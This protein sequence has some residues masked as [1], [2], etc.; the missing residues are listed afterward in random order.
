MSLN[1]IQEIMQILDENQE[2]ISEND[3]LK[4]CNLLKDLYDVMHPYDTDCKPKNY[5]IILLY[6]LVFIILYL[7]EIYSK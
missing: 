4:C 1:N 3:Y 6:V 7:L 2:H 5:I